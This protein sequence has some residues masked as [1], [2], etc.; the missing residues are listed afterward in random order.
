MGEWHPIYPAGSIGPL[1]DTKEQ[2]P[3]GQQEITSPITLKAVP[4]SSS[5]KCHEGGSN[6][7]VE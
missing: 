5:T 1:Q 7:S 3:W 2:A 4:R 6:P